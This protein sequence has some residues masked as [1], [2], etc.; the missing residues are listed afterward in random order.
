M[1]LTQAEKEEWL[2]RIVTTNTRAYKSSHSDKLLTDSQETELFDVMDLVEKDGG[3]TEEEY[4]RDFS[5]AFDKVAD[6]LKSLNWGNGKIG[7][8]NVR[9]GNAMPLMVKKVIFYICY[10]AYLIAAK[11]DRIK[12]VSQQAILNEINKRG[13]S[14][15]KNTW[16]KWGMKPKV[17]YETVNY[18][19][20]PY[21][22]HYMGEKTHQLAYAIN[23]LAYYSGGYDRFI[24]LFGGGGTV[25]NSIIKN[26][27][28]EYFIN[29]LD[30]FVVNYYRVLQNKNNC[31]IMIE[32]LEA[33]QKEFKNKETHTEKAEYSV[34]L[35]RNYDSLSKSY[36]INT[37][38]I[39]A[40]I[41]HVFLQS[42]LYNRISKCSSG[43]RN[44]GNIKKFENCD[45]KEQ[46]MHLHKQFSRLVVLDYD[47]TGRGDSEMSFI[48]ACVK[49]SM[50][51]MLTHKWGSRCLLYSDSPYESTKGYKQKFN[52]QM[53]DTLIKDLCNSGHKFIFSCRA[54][55][56]VLKQSEDVDF[57]P[58][59]LYELNLDKGGHYAKPTDNK[60]LKKIW[61]NNTHIYFSVFKKFE[62][63]LE[64]QQLFVLCI[65]QQDADKTSR[66]TLNWEF[67]M[68]HLVEV[69]ICNYKFPNPMDYKR[70]TDGKT[71]IFETYEYQDFMKE[72]DD[73]NYIRG[74]FPI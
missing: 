51:G 43:A 55:S 72:L 25:S 18:R 47:A 9:Q 27:N 14:L 63:F 15:G 41:A 17:F 39:E 52:S 70:E 12:E 19:Q 6:V 62:E 1:S 3:K 68:Q 45:F 38:A 22:M 20:Y 44:K 8:K 13:F 42:F 36:D 56:Y 24:D 32:K 4:K 59:D 31:E 49:F 65:I 21:V 28:S 5:L 50:P 26:D 67:S 35:F 48:D 33:I 64:Q 58:E 23:W 11:K 60:V 37:D 10:Q 54:G 66:P 69:M 16:T 74:S 30:P 46:I 29:E 2:E 40:A 61:E 34:G 73:D 53:M 57:T 7:V 71:Y